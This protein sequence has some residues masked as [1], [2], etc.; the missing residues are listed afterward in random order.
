MTLP[1]RP[2]VAA[3]VPIRMSPVL[4]SLL[5]PVLKYN[6]PLMPAAPA[7]KLRITTAPLDDPVPSPDDTRTAPPVFTVLRPAFTSTAPPEPQVP[8][9]TL[10]T[11]APARPAVATPEPKKTAPL[12]PAFA[13]PVLKNSAPLTPAAPPS[14]D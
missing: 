10:T 9:P 5:D 1:A 3:P 14:A 8:L 13:V 6:D 12:L 4:P 11:T 2:P 7:F